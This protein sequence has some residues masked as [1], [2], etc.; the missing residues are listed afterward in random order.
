M[1]G[2]SREI[3]GKPDERLGEVPVDDWPAPLTGHGLIRRRKSDA[4]GMGGGRICRGRQ[5]GG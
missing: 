1:D 3:V 2:R 5:R 4:K